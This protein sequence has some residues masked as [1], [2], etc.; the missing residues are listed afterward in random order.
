MATRRLTPVAYVRRTTSTCA[1]K[2]GRQHAGVEDDDVDL[3]EWSGR[4]VQERVLEVLADVML[5]LR[6]LPQFSG[7]R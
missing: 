6:D 5:G 2:G 4:P 3:A 1:R 7:D